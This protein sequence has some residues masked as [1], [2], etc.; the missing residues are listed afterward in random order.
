MSKQIDDNVLSP[1]Q[2]IDISGKNETVR[3]AVAKG[4]IE[5]NAATLESIRQG[6]IIKGDVLAV[7]QTAGI[8]AAKD[9]QRLIP[10]CHPLLLTNIYIEFYLP[11]S[12][13]FIDITATSKGIGKTGFEMEAFIA[14]TVSALNIYDMCK[15]IDKSMHITNVRLLKKSGGKSGTYVAE[16]GKEKPVNRYGKVV[17]VCIGEGKDKKE[18]VSEAVL[19]EEYGFIG[20]THAGSSRQVSLLAQETVN[21]MIIALSSI[22][23]QRMKTQNI[24]IN[25]GDSA[26]NLLTNNIDLIS[27]Q[28]GTRI[29]IGK[30]AVLQVCE[31]GKEYHKPGYYLIPLEGIF[32]NVIKGG[33]IKPG[34]DIIVEENS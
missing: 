22:N 30:E 34:D 21:K 8:L 33:I 20:D 17:A 25:P 4:R 19:R 14:V 11:P 13:S 27:L 15:A 10:L 29:H 1:V 3:E 32:A 16:D 6:E 7:A 5:M 18:Q 23:P 31:I 9:T 24:R 2:M 28:V 12:G 26:E